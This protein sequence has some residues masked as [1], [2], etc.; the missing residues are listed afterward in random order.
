[1][2]K[3]IKG[4][5]QNDQESDVLN[6]LVDMINDNHNEQKKIHENNETEIAKSEIHIITKLLK[7]L[8]VK[9]VVADANITAG[10]INTNVPVEIFS[11]KY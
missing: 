8:N 1:M 2:Q 7:L 3:L 9:N 4:D 11:I 10:N 5:D 6:F